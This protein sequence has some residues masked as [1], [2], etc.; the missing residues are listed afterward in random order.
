MPRPESNAWRHEGQAWRMVK[1]EPQVQFRNSSLLHFIVPARVV[2]AIVLT[3]SALL[4]AYAQAPSKYKNDTFT[5]IS[6][7]DHGR[8]KVNVRG[9]GDHCWASNSEDQTIAFSIG[10]SLCTWGP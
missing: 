9:E 4:I 3:A 8:V 6:R 7:S 1:G 10:D 5:V 2:T